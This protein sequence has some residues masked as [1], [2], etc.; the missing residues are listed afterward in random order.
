[1]FASF[2]CH[3]FPFGEP[4]RRGARPGEPDFGAWFWGPPGPRRR[5]FRMGGR[6]FEQGDLKLVILR[7]L[8]EKPRH[9]YEIIKALEERSGGAYAPSPGTVYPTLTLLEDLGYARATP[10]EGGRKIYEIT[11]EGRAHL[12]EHRSTVEDIFER[13]NDFGGAVFGAAIGEIAAGAATIGRA[14]FAAA[15][16]VHG[17]SEKLRR[18]REIMERAAREIND[19]AW[20]ASIGGTGGRS[21][22]GGTG[23]TGSTGGAQQV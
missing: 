20:A 5:G 22:T 14:A 19:L 17:D 11:P 21:G 13:I 7:L 4:P 3:G 15:S 12:A 16:K 9:G 6:M 18:I 8:D 2:G 10:E 1:M 23:N